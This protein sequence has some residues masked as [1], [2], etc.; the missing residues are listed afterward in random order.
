MML[1]IQTT[2]WGWR[3]GVKDA[4]MFQPGQCR[5]I[6]LAAEATLPT[7][8][9]MRVALPQFLVAPHFLVAQQRWV[10]LLILVESQV[11]MTALRG[12]A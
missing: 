11:L 7:A 2:V 1:S 3:V 9:Q 8:V 6:R 10:A 5:M 4:Q 12:K